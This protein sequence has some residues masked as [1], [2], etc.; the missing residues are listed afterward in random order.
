MVSDGSTFRLDITGSGQPGTRNLTDRS[1]NDVRQNQ[2][3]ASSLYW[4]VYTGG[5]DP[6]RLLSALESGGGGTITAV[7]TSATSGLSGGMA[8]GDVD[9]SLDFDNLTALAVA[10]TD[11]L[12]HRKP[13]TGHGSFTVDALSSFLE[14]DL[15]LNANRITAGTMA[16]DRLG[17][18][19]ATSRVLEWASGVPTWELP[20][21]SVGAGAGLGGG[22]FAGAVTLSLNIAPLPGGEIAGGDR[23]ALADVSDNNNPHGHSVG[24]LSVFLT[25]GD[26]TGLIW[27]NQGSD[28]DGRLG[29]ELGGVVNAHLADDTI[30]EVK[31]D[32]TNDPTADYVLGWMMGQE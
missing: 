28:T 18:G 1:G 11:I 10:G 8:S 15:S 17:S 7:N 14:T 6:Y 27:G 32:I 21:T 3:F 16:S 25:G 2:L 12:A 13:G 19:G 20:I 23:M 4:A 22:G 26:N 31:M 29:L 9:L 30:A 5:S 24:A